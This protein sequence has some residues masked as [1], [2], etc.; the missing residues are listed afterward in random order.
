MAAA[1]SAGPPQIRQSLSDQWRDQFLAQAAKAFDD[2][3][4]T[5]KEARLAH[6]NVRL[7]PL[8]GALTCELKQSDARLA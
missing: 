3:Q 2:P 5:R 4:R 6:E 8:V 1:R 7:T